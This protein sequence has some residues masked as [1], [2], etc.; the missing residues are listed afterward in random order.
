M[1]E[2]DFNEFVALL[3]EISGNLSIFS[4]VGGLKAVFLEVDSTFFVYLSFLAV[5]MFYKLAGR[6]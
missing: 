6:N 5:G 1:I 2:L 3:G 4:S